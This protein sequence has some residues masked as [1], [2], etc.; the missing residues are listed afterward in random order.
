M[1]TWDSTVDVVIVGSGGGGM[2]AALAAADAGASA[3]V[4]EKQELLGGSTAMSGG[5]VWVP[6]N[7]VMRAV[8]VPDSYEDA[9]VHFEAVVGD[10]GPCSS[11]ERR[12]RLSDGGAGNGRLPAAARGSIRLLPWLQRL[13]LEREGR[14]RPR[15][16]DRADSVRW[17]GARRMAGASCSPG[18]PRASAWR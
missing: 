13:L 14:S 3:V 8:G 10:V 11:F 6:N 16:R 18:W 15:T 12:A 5:I 4:L 9:M 2:V 17:S 1:T 7:P